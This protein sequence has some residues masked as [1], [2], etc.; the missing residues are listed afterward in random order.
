MTVV[1]GGRHAALPPAPDRP[2]PARGRGPGRGGPG[3]RVPW[4]TPSAL[5]ALLAG[6]VLLSLAWGAFG[7]WVADQHASAART[8]TTVDEPLSLDAQDMY[9][10]IADADATVTAALLAS[11]QPGP[12]PLARYSGDVG[13][14][15]ADLSQIRAGDSGTGADAS[16][17]ALSNGLQAY[18]GYVGEARTEYAMGYPQTGGSFVQVASEEAHLVLLP[19]A[20]AVF[21]RE[22]AAR[23][24][25]SSQATGWP[26]AIAAFVLA[27]ITGYVLYRAQRWLTGRTNRIVS[28]GLAL[29]SVALVVSVVW[30]AAGLVAAR[31]DLGRGIG[32]GSAPAQNLA[33]ASIGVQQ[34]RGDAVLNVISRSGSA[35]F[36][37]NFRA[38]VKQVGPGAGSWLGNAAAAQDGPGDAAL[39]AAAARDTTA[40]YAANQGVYQLGSAARYADEQNLV[41]GSG[42]GATTAGYNALEKDLGAA[43]GADQ[44]VFQSAASAGSR[45]LGPLAWVVIAAALLMAAC[46]GWAVSRRL[47]EY[48]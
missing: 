10:S 42:S 32:N 8:L 37:D 26:L 18:A 20:R 28:P 38:T 27:A 36:A 47:A 12:V 45:V 7:G 15:A 17:S 14:A 2:A 24:A 40:W 48:R 23:D 3:H 9:Q 35:S 44:S 46:C 13:Q 11:S 30:L 25:A 1:A 6:L 39:V 19:A 33:L 16:L 29:A 34:I 21:D 43:I 4:S 31:D 5:R 41:V 22:N